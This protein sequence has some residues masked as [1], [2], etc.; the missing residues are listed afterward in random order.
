MRRSSTSDRLSSHDRQCLGREA[1]TRDR[2]GVRSRGWKISKGERSDVTF[3]CGE[4]PSV[5]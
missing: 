2:E 5:G 3:G 4:G 1:G